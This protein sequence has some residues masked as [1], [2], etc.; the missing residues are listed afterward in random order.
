MSGLGEWDEETP[1]IDLGN[2]PEATA[3]DLIDAQIADAFDPLVLAKI[4]RDETQ[5]EIRKQIS[6]VAVQ[7]VR[8]ALTPERLE[9]IRQIA[10]AAAQTALE[11]GSAA[12]DEDD[13]TP[14]L[15]YPSLDAWVREWLVPLYRRKVGEEGRADRRWAAEWFRSDEA[16]ARLDALW[17][18][19]E[20][21]RL[22]ARTGMSVWFRDHADHHMAVLMSPGGPWGTSKDIAT[23]LDPL[24]YAKPDPKLYPDVRDQ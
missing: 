2:A 19:W 13:D 15:Y 1:T 9:Q 16:V 21:L 10:E 20:F 23:S 17:R 6:K 18:A 5:R 14:S 11:E 22:D 4:V 24:P 8:S 12:E 7:A 3:G